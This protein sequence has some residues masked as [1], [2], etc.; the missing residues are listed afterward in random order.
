MDSVQTHKEAR[1]TFQSLVHGA[2]A[3]GMLSA[4]PALAL[5]DQVQT[6]DTK[7]GPVRITPLFHATAMIEAGGAVIYI[8]PAKPA[9]IAGLKPGN[10][11]LITDIHSDHMDTADLAAL[12]NPD[13]VLVAP[14]AVQQT[15]TNARVLANGES[16]TWRGWKITAV[17]LQGP[18]QWLRA[19]LWRQKLLLCRR[20]RGHARDARAEEH[21][22]RLYSHESALHHDA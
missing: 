5:P 7:A 9:N 19:H 17:P 8:D 1:M 6:F 18:R 14:A 22:R 13:T 15:V 16:M 2:L 10:L 21:R 12:S 11:I 20:H 3:L 4:L